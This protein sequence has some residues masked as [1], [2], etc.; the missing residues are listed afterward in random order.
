MNGKLEQIPAR[1]FVDV[2]F[3]TKS[4]GEESNVMKL[5]AH[6]LFA[7]FL[8][9]ILPAANSDVLLFDAIQAQSGDVK[10]PTRGLSMDQVRSRYGEPGNEIPWVGDPPITRWVYDDYTV[11]FEYKYV[12][13]SVVHR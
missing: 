1:E 7:V 2:V 13:N 3:Y 6:F 10:K 11:Y 5:L 9:T 4:P 12:I 8:L